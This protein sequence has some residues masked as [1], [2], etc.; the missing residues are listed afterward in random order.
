VS[1]LV[2]GAGLTL[3]D[4][5]RVAREDV[6]VAL[7]PGARERMLASRQVV[8]RSVLDG[9]SVYGLSTA[10]GVLKRVGLAD[11]AAAYSSEMLRSHRVA[12]GPPAAR[13]HV[14]ATMLRLLNAYASGT[15]G[16]RPRLAE[17]LVDALNGGIVPPVRTLGSVGQA[18]LAPMADL[19]W[20]LFGDEPL[21]AGEG[22]ALV[23]SNAFSTAWAALAVHDAR[24]LLDASTAAGALALEALS[25]NRSLLHPG[26]G[27]VRPYPGLR[28]ALA[29]LGRLLE[30]SYL[31]S[32]DAR[33]SLQDP[34]TFRNLPH[35]LGACRGAARDRAQR[36]R[37]QPRHPARGAGAGVGRQLRGP[38]GRRRR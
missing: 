23:S 12:Q 34:L 20:V 10:V 35:L 38:A 16:V 1:V 14:R 22:L 33:R 3:T 11:Q 5:V 19:A 7:A 26:I 28:R 17:R 9:A 31:H 21:E 24:E 36:L 2:S 13:D 29:R 15:T 30:G 8:E 32:P 37:Q 18:D 27:E 6:P 4:L 25:A